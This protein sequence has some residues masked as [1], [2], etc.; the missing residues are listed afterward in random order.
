MIIRHTDEDLK[1]AFL[2]KAERLGLTISNDNETKTGIEHIKLG[3]A[4]SVGTSD[5]FHVNWARNYDYYAK[6]EIVPV[7]D[8]Q[9]D[10]KKI[11]NRLE[12]YAQA[13][14]ED[15]N[16]VRLSGGE[17]VEV[18]QEAGTAN[19]NG[20]DFDEDEINAL[21]RLL[22]LG[23]PVSFDGDV[24]NVDGTEVTKKDLDK[25]LNLMA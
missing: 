20:Y 14:E 22:D 6:R 3:D 10:W 12:A 13:V 4:I 18:D 5:K 8:L 11:V 15:N 21:S 2:A 17:E 25:V 24:L 16:V 1:D 23:T 9:L 7:Y 19:I